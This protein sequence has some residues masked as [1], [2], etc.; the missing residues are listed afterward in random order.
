MTKVYDALRRAEATRQKR[1]ENTSEEKPHTLS[2]L[3]TA[4]KAEADDGGENVASATP[5][6]PAATTPT[7]VTPTVGNG[8]ELD[9]LREIVFGSQINE[10]GTAVAEL[11][12]KL[13]HEEEQVKLEIDKL[14]KRLEERLVEIDTRTGRGQTE[15]RDQILKMSNE[16]CERINSRGDHVLKIANEGLAELRQRKLDESQF[17][18]VLRKLASGV[19]TKKAD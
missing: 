9:R 12:A 3:F 15:L 16:L 13:V 5:E 19:E 17:T 6:S 14:E 10:F 7:P 1:N 8:G 18:E 4:P 2:E 11:E